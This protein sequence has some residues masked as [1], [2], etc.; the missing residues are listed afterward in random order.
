MA[1]RPK[2]VFVITNGLILLYGVVF[3]H[4][5][6]LFAKTMPSNIT[7]F[8]GVIFILMILGFFAANQMKEWGRK[9]VVYL[10]VG[11]SI[12]FAYL[13]GKFPGSVHPGYIIMNVI[14][15]LFYN[16]KRI[17]FRFNPDW[18]KIRKSILVIDDDDGIQRSVQKV[19]LPN[20]YSVLTATSGERGLQIAKVQ[21]PDLILLDVILPGIKGREVCSQLKED[22]ETRDI[23]VIFLTAKNS[24]DDINAEMAVGAASHIAKPVN[25]KILLAEIK[26][27]LG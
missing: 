16:Q 12:Y 22:E 6:I 8:T 20:G 14:A 10:M 24:P 21:K 7:I 11:L 3:I 9:L 4:L 27:L 1:N 15:I 17:R 23:P 25:A 2:S 18:S 19:L 26:K 5:L 13:M